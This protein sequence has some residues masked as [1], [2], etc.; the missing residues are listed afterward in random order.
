MLTEKLQTL[1]ELANKLCTHED[2]KK[3]GPF[4]KLSESIA[5]IQ[6]SRKAL[7]SMLWAHTGDRD[8]APSIRSQFGMT[9]HLMAELLGVMTLYYRELERDAQILRIDRKA[10]LRLLE[11]VLEAKDGEHTSG[12]TPF[13]WRPEPNDLIWMVMNPFLMVSHSNLSNWVFQIPTSKY[14]VGVDST[15]GCAFILGPTNTIHWASKDECMIC[16]TD[17]NPAFNF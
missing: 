11:K 16:L 15:T 4:R 5:C 13:T 6:C 12:P 10:L 8:L 2:Q 3:D 1:T 9:L 7:R 17:I 14:R